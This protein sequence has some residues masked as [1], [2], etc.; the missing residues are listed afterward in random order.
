MARAREVHLQGNYLTFDRSKSFQLS[1]N[2]TQKGNN[3]ASLEKEPS[4]G[5]ETRPSQIENFQDSDSSYLSSESEDLDER[6]LGEIVERQIESRNSRIGSK[7]KPRPPPK[8]VSSVG[9]MKRAVSLGISPLDHGRNHESA[10]KK[11]LLVNASGRS[12]KTFINTAIDPHVMKVMS[13]GTV[14][15]S[16]TTLAGAEFGLIGNSLTESKEFVTG[17]AQVLDILLKHATQRIKKLLAPSK[18]K[19]RYQGQINVTKNMVGATGIKTTK[20]ADGLRKEHPVGTTALMGYVAQPIQNKPQSVETT[21][22]AP[23]PH[24][25]PK[26]QQKWYQL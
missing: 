21:F 7:T 15:V 17:E 13:D 22:V 4:S 1:S 20:P 8:K 10:V 26:P 19:R 5:P 3:L 25:P 16:D 6:A 18:R 12:I 11:R 9:N 2:S 23:S 24:L 14:M